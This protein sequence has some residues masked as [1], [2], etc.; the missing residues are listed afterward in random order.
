MV[1]YTQNFIDIP[2]LP[3]GTIFFFFVGNIFIYLY[4]FFFYFW[5]SNIY[6][7]YPSVDPL[8]LFLAFDGIN[9]LKF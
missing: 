4:A 5:N 6:P 8:Q 3:S 9:D 2:L 1:F 7:V